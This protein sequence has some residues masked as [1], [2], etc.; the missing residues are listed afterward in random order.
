M[1]IYKLH[2]EIQYNVYGRYQISG[3]CISFWKLSL[4][5]ICQSAGDAYLHQ[6]LK[7]AGLSKKQALN[8]L[9]A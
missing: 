7:K 2:E 9:K 1:G 5:I 6:F 3:F 4:S 8:V